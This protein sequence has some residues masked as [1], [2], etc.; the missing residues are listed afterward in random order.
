MLI[1]KKLYIKDFLSFEEEDIYFKNN[2]TTCVMGKNLTEDNSESN[3]SGKSALQSAIELSLTGI[4][5]RKVTKQKL[6]R[7]GQDKAIISLTLFNSFKNEELKIVRTLPFKGSEKINIYLNDKEVDVA[8][9]KDANDWIINYIG[10]S[11]EDIS[12]Y[13]IP[14]EVSYTSFFNSSDTAKK[15]LISRFS[16]ADIVDSVFS[17]VDKDISLKQEK[18]D[19]KQK[20]IDTTDG[21]L[22]QLQ[23]DLEKE[24]LVDFE[25]EKSEKITNLNTKIES[26][27]NILEENKTKLQVISSDLSYLNETIISSRITSLNVFKTHLNTF[28]SSS[29]DFNLEYKNINDKIDQI[30]E[31]EKKVDSIKKDIDSDIYSVDRDIAKMELVLSGKVE[32]PKC[33]HQF[34]PKSEITVEDAKIKIDIFNK[35]LEKFSEEL[36]DLG[37]LKEKYSIQK[38]EVRESERVISIEQKEFNAKKIKIEKVVS[39]IEDS[40][41]RF[42][43]KIELHTKQLFEIE[44]DE[45]INTELIDKYK[46]QIKEIKKSEKDTIKEDQIRTNISNLQK[47]KTN[48]ENEKLRT[49]QEQESITEWTTNFKLFKSYLANKKLRIIQDMINKYLQ[50]MKCDYKLKLEGYKVLANGKDMREKITP[51][52]YKDGELCDYGEFSKGERTRIDFATLLTLQ[53]LV[54]DNTDNPLD[55]LFVDEIFEGTD[56]LGL[57]NILNISRDTKKTVYITT[58]I[59]N[60]N[61]IEDIIIIEKNNGVSKINK[62]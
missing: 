12:N 4:V 6:I 48:L 50:D 39:L 25:S 32:C 60:E 19:K 51:Y 22:I 16:N 10:I 55:I 28:V 9:T 1:P 24:L 62:N 20:E 15:E 57:T 56:S 14:N 44:E 41:R 13:F 52:I 27:N 43:R 2:C 33:K 46:D 49:I 53:T 45:K 40:I 34:N 30:L 7:R 5:S 54:N 18:I 36:K 3:G 35:E 38:N 29:K 21:R 47:L 8:T 17:K 26:C 37:K 23:E 58:H 11:R 59:I 42:S 61:I 31:K